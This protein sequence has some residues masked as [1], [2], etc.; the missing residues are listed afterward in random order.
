MFPTLS[1]SMAV[2]I[3]SRDLGIAYL[4]TEKKSGSIEKPGRLLS[5]MIRLKEKYLKEIQPSLLKSVGYKNIN[6]VPKLQ[7]I[8][9]NIGVGEAIQDPKKLE[10]AAKEIAVI[11]GQRP[12]T[13]RARKSI[14][15]F[16]NSRNNPAPLSR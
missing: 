6:Q 11:T 8:V 15:N 4:L 9:I 5:K 13:R 14:S 1:I 2:P 7:K 16:N 12:V 10:N 3:Q